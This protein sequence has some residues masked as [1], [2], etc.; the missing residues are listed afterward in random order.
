MTY[1]SPDIRTHK[2]KTWVSYYNEVVA[3]NKLFEV[4]K[5][6]RN[7]QV[8][9][10]LHLVCTDEKGIA[11]YDDNGNYTR[12]CIRKIA[13]ILNGGNFGI[14]PEYCVLGFS[15]DHLFPEINNT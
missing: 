10:L 6:D 8:G 11:E 2:L 15:V 14:D 13:Y 4:R 3:N 5:N 1:N 7:F 9:D 12:S